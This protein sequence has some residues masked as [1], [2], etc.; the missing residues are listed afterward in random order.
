M[1]KV[2]LS[3]FSNKWYNPGSTAKRIVWYIVN[4][5]FFKCPLPYPNILKIKLL[6]MFGAKMSTGI[7]IKPDVNIKYPWF[8]EIGNNSWIGER[9]WIDNLAF[10]KIG[11]NVCISQGAY[12]CTGNHN[13]KSE[14]F[15]LLTGEIIIEDGVWIG[16][17][18]IICPGV[19]LR[20]HSVITAGCIISD[21]TEPY[22]IYK[23]NETVEVK[24]RIIE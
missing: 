7:V 5:V 14:S 10:V 22:T 3:L 20:S 8:L 12:L 24:S 19:T 13:Y 18:S 6:R 17:K 15:D 9:V 23:T 11:K 16:A 21:N 2:D 1:K 4:I